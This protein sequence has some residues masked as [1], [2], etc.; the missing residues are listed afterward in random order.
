MRLQ[1]PNVDLVVRDVTLHLVVDFAAKARLNDEGYRTEPMGDDDYRIVRN[2]GKI[3]EIALDCVQ[4]WEGIEDAEGQP[5]EYS[6]ASAE[7][8]L[9]PGMLEEI[10]RA[11]WDAVMEDH[12]I[13]RLFA[14]MRALAPTP[15]EPS[16]TNHLVEKTVTATEC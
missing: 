1:N 13:E 14:A 15:E 11:F 8:G 5:V 4:S 2:S 16:A 9:S 3:T 6:R 7:Q 12:P 10:G